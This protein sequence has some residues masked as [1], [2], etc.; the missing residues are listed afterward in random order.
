MEDSVR[1]IPFYYIGDTNA[2]PD[3]KQ[4]LDQRSIAPSILSLLSVPVP[5]SMDQPAI[6]N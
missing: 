2:L 6:F 3:A 4:V 5:E 1:D